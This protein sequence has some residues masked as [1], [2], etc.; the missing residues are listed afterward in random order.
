MILNWDS[1]FGFGLA[2]YRYESYFRLYIV[3]VLDDRSSNVHIYSIT[4]NLEASLI[5]IIHTK[6]LE[7]ARQ[8]AEEDAQAI[9]RAI[10]DRIEL[11]SM[12]PE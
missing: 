3:E 9:D 8:E 2:L 12:Y 10:K 11:Y 6:D 7:T 4:G 5:K 1:L